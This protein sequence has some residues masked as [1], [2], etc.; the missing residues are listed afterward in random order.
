M[1]SAHFGPYLGGRLTGK[2]FGLVLRREPDLSRKI[3]ELSAL[4]ERMCELSVPDRV[5]M[6]GK[7]LMALGGSSGT[8]HDAC[9]V[10]RR[11]GPLTRIAGAGTNIK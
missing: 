9:R 11:R 7:I 6:T 3:L 8:F 4:C 2:T 10:G 1:H 5:L